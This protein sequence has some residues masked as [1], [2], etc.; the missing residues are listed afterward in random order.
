MLQ[1]KIYTGVNRFF[2][3]LDANSKDYLSLLKRKGAYRL[4]NRLIGVAVPFTT[5]NGFQVEEIRNGYIRCKIPLKGNSNHF[6]T[7]YAGAMFL[8]VEVPGGVIAL[9]ELGDRYLPILKE[10]TMRYVKVCKTDATV[11]FSLPPGRWQAYRETVEREGRCE[12]TLEGEVFDTEGQ[13]VATS[14]A[15]YV[16][17]IK[18]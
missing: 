9:F 18:R 2:N 8:L 14:T 3:Q 7:L 15:H 5:R 10:L 6:N 16:L 1:D 17:C 12:F 11:A 13:L 4:L